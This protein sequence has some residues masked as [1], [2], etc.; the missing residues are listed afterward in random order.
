VRLVDPPPAHHLPL[1]LCDTTARLPFPSRHDNE[2]A[3]LEARSKREYAAFVERAE[4]TLS[5]VTKSIQEQ[6]Q[7]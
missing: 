3:E 6:E 5:A 4:A 1:L 7:L 2:L